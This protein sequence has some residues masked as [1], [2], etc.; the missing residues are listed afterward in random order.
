[1]LEKVEH[2]KGSFNN[3]QQSL[4]GSDQMA[5]IIDVQLG[6]IAYMDEEDAKAYLDKLTES[7]ES[8][9]AKNIPVTWVTMSKGNQ[10]HEPDKTAIGHRP[11]SELEGM[12]FFGVRPDM[13]G[14]NEE[15][16]RNFIRDHGPRK[17]EAVY[18]KFFKGAF[19]DPDEY[20]SKP[21]LQE[22]LREDYGGGDFTL[23]KA[24]DFQGTKLVDYMRAEGVKNPLVMGAVSSHCVCETATG[25]VLKGFQPTICNDLVVG[26]QGDELEEG[27]KHS[28]MVWREPDASAVAMND[29]H[30]SRMNGK[31]DSIVRDSQRREISE[32]QGAVMR[33]IPIVTFGQSTDLEQPDVSPR[34]HKGHVPSAGLA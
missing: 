21:G 1:M 31:I 16:F 3:R 9:R 30:T 17:N 28:R 12:D 18:C 27:Y 24:G 11:E 4:K 19:V 20:E 6:C 5:L 2:I 22:S 32:S 23:P 7:V 10:L 26:W 14:K 8:M 15:I 25:A 13:K 33:A 29:W 34:L